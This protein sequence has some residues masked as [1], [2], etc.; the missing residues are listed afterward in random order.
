MKISIGV[1]VFRDFPQEL[2][3]NIKL[4]HVFKNM[5]YMYDI[6]YC[7]TNDDQVFGFGKYFRENH[8]DPQTNEAP[9]KT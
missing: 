7:V 4:L 6:V 8:T 5:F 3:Q 2:K 1:K 9:G